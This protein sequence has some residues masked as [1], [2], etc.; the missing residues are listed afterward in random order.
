MT[1]KRFQLNLEKQK[2]HRNLSDTKLYLKKWT[3][4]SLV[5][6]GEVLALFHSAQLKVEV[7]SNYYVLEFTAA[8]CKANDST[9]FDDIISDIDEFSTMEGEASHRYYINNY[10]SAP[11]NLMTDLKY[12][13]LVTCRTKINFYETKILESEGSRLVTEKENATLKLMIQ[14]LEKRIENLQIFGSLIGQEVSHRF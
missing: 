3:R 7:I 1:P 6:T 2:I 12:A 10:E 8:S 14:R 11:Q 9:T 5:R 13:F 4:N